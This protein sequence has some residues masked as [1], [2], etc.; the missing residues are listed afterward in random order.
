MPLVLVQVVFLLQ[1]ERN[2][3]DTDSSRL[4]RFGQKAEMFWMETRPT[5]RDVG[6]TQK[7]VKALRKSMVKLQRMQSREVIPDTKTYNPVLDE[8]SSEIQVSQS[9][10]KAGVVIPNLKVVR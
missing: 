7:M 3:I 2:N 1:N 5:K 6:K 8:L 9:A 10:T 4:T